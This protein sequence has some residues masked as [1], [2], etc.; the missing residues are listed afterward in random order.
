MAMPEAQRIARWEA[1]YAKTR[2]CADQVRSITNKKE[3]MIAYW[4]CRAG[5]TQ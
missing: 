1:A 4:R 2:Q 5:E 3:R